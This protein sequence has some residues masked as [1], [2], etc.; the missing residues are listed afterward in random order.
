[1]PNTLP[2]KKTPAAPDA[3]L[4]VSRAGIV[5]PVMTTDPTDD[6]FGGAVV[7]GTVV[8]QAGANDSYYVQWVRING[9]W[10]ATF[11]AT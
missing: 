1:M 7:D 2:L 6:A 5:L 10:R 9:T 11:M 4:D 8:L 3:P